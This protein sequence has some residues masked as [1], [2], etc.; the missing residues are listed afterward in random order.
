MDMNMDIDKEKKEKKQIWAITSGKGGVGKS[1]LSSSFAICMARKGKS[2]I[3]ID[4]DLHGSN[5]HTCLGTEPC[6]TNLR[7]FLSGQVNLNDLLQPTT[8]PNLSFIQGVWDSW[9]LFNFSDFHLNMLFQSIESLTA[10]LI[11]LDLSSANHEIYLN[12]LNKVDRRVLVTTPEPMSVERTYRFFEHYLTHCLCSSMTPLEKNRFIHSLYKYRTENQ[13]RLFSF[14]EF[15]EVQDEPLRE[16]F[17][18]FQKTQLYLIVN[19]CRVKSH[20]KLGKAMES[21]C[22][23]YYDMDIQVLGSV[24]F[25]NTVWQSLEKRKAPA[26]EKT[27]FSPMPQI[28]SMC[29]KLLP[30]PSS[31]YLLRAY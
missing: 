28:L 4:L 18:A 15:I 3:L 14:G 19:A 7:H 31:P 9:Q 23:K 5:L 25:D 8:I 12:V 30:K 10:D 22:L 29:K 16:Y 24:E 20:F 21:L 27:F 6:S 11:L 13:K 26:T 17:Q 1:F 2:V